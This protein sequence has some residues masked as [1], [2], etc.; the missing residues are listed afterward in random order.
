MLLI[1]PEEFLRKFISSKKEPNICILTFSKNYVILATFSGTIVKSA[2]LV[3]TWT[4]SDSSFLYENSNS[5][6][7]FQIESKFFLHCPEILGTVAKNALHLRMQRKFFWEMKST[8]VNVGSQMKFKNWANYL[9]QCCQ[10]CF[11]HVQT[12]IFRKIKSFEKLK[13]AIKFKSWENF[14]LVSS[15]KLDCSS[16]DKILRQN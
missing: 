9:S 7:R 15:S 6:T 2:L 11:V 1:Y 14:F 3:S 4:F 8:E 13:F 12:D 10:N 5:Y 16:P